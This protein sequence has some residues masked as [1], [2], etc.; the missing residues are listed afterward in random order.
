[1][2]NKIIKINN[3]MRRRFLVKALSLQ[4]KIERRRSSG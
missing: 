1:M 3:T 2:I 4:K